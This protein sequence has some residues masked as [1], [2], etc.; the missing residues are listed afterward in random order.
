MPANIFRCGLQRDVYAK[1]EGFLEYWRAIAI[2]Y[3]GD[4]ISALAKFSHGP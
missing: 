3:D 2:V 1:I 4:D